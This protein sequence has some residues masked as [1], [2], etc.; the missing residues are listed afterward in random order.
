MLIVYVWEMLKI[1]Q[2]QMVLFTVLLSLVA[3]KVSAE[4]DRYIRFGIGVEIPSSSEFIDED[5]RN[6]NF[7]WLYGCGLGKDDTPYR[8]SAGEFERPAVMELGVGLEVAENFRLE[9]V[10]EIRPTYK[11]SGKANYRISS[12]I[13]DTTASVSTSS[14]MTIG[15]VDF[16]MFMVDKKHLSPFIGF[17][18]GVTRNEVKDFQIKFPTY[19]THVLGGTDIDF[20]WT[21]SIGIAQKISDQSTLEFALRY[22]DLGS[23]N[24]GL[25]DGSIRY[26]NPSR[27]PLS[28][29]NLGKVKADLRTFG[30]RISLRYAF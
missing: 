14:V 23:V 4:S 19:T 18:I 28:L 22:S 30:V 12:D 26:R 24:T 10:L 29:P 21:A 3:T 11:F 8:R 5:C 27:V 16:P 15:Y 7:S 6:D 17:G 20:A 1:K 25:G 13:Q 2:Y 9:S